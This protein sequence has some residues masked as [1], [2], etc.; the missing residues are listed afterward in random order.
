[1][2]VR[3]TD[4]NVLRLLFVGLVKAR[5]MNLVEHVTCMGKYYMHTTFWPGKANERDDI[6]DFA[7]DGVVLLKSILEK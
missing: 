4:E 6:G 7:V 5:R 3:F 2:T 1:M